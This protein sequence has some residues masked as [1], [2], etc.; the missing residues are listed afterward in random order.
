ML[1]HVAPTHRNEVV[2]TPEEDIHTAPPLKAI[3]LKVQDIG[4]LIV[5][6]YTSWV[7]YL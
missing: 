6:S 2:F 1:A 5:I 7:V 3:M 4:E